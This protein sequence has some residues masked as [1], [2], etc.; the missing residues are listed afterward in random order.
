MPTPI[1]R[2]AVRGLLAAGFATSAIYAGRVALA[3]YWLKTATVP[4]IQ[5]S[6]TIIS[7]RADSYFQLG[8]MTAD[9]DDAQSFQAFQTAA[10]LNPLD[11]RPLIELGLRSELAGDPKTAEALFLKAADIDHQY[12]PRWTLANFYLRRNDEQNFW[13]W[14]NRTL[15]MEYRPFSPVFRLCWNISD[16]AEDIQQRLKLPNDRLKTGYLAY[17]V[18]AQKADAIFDAASRVA[19][20]VPDA[21][22]VHLYGACERLIQSKR[23]EQATELWN[24]LVDEKRI[25]YAKL[26]PASGQLVTNPSFALKTSSRGFDW[27]IGNVNGVEITGVGSS[28]GLRVELTGEQPESCELLSQFI[29]VQQSTQYRFGADWNATGLRSD[30]GL[31][32]QI[33]D[34]ASN[35]LLATLTPADSGSSSSLSVEVPPGTTLLRCALRYSRP[36]GQTRAHGTLE[37]KRLSFQR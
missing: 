17:V 15:E 35:R 5:R 27:R 37:I 28:E 10:T 16:S 24:L 23:T 36:L 21:S 4:G 7:D 8:V 33:Y 26:D 22:V 34:P 20:T 32:F 9:S 11:S 6:T 31:G 25:P 30:S 1:V 14:A 19:K 29:P 13:V 3:D 12:L 2:T 18:A